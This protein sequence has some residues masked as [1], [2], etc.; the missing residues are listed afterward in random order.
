[1]AIKT[2]RTERKQVERREMPITTAFCVITEEI[3]QNSQEAEEKPE[4]RVRP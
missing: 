3:P 1:M 4:K 2:E